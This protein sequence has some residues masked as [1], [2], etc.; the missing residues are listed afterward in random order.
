[1]T[2]LHSYSENDFRAILARIV[3]F[4]KIFNLHGDLNMLTQDI[5][6]KYKPDVRI[7]KQHDLVQFIFDNKNEADKFCDL[8]EMISNRRKPIE[9][10]N[11]IHIVRLR[12]EHYD[13][14][15]PES[16][17][18]NELKNH[19]FYRDGKG[20]PPATQFVFHTLEVADRYLKEFKKMNIKIISLKGDEIERAREG[21]IIRTDKSGK[22]KLLSLFPTYFSDL[23]PFNLLKKS[24]E[25]YTTL[26]DGL[27]QKIFQGCG[28]DLKKSLLAIINQ[29]YMSSRLKFEKI[30]S[31]LRDLK[32]KNREGMGAFEQLFLDIE[33]RAQKP[34]TTAPSANVS[35]FGTTTNQ[36]TN[37]RTSRSTGSSFFSCNFTFATVNIFQ[38]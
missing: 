32:N 15:L 7:G 9:S 22:I 20:N 18:I 28:E 24:E 16:V 33:A 27:K 36:P 13:S 3:D 35:R 12:Q 25:E 38:P 1:M 29:F 19:C 2:S 14:F 26:L 5:D 8:L 30:M 4:D 21:F 17:T 23:Q 6:V 37:Q 34:E 11:D 10:I 31:I